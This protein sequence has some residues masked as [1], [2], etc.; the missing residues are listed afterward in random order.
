MYRLPAMSDGIG[1]APV[2]AMK[3]G[4]VAT[5]QL[6]L[7]QVTGTLDPSFG[8]PPFVLNQLTRSLTDL[9]HLVD[10]ISLDSPSV[11]WL[12]DLPGHPRAFGSGLGKFGY[13]RRFRRWLQRHATDYDAVIVHGIWQYQSH[14]DPDAPHADG[15]FRYRA[16]KLDCDVCTLKSRDAAPVWT[17]AR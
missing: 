3:S 12:T 10:V 2:D 6:R 15:F 14:R 9:G 7:L 17:R 8:G 5:P 4:P 13:S 1:E 16:S 11:P